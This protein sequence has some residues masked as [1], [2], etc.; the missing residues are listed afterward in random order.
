MNEDA[1]MQMALAMSLET[2]NQSKGQPISTSTNK[3]NSQISISST[4]SSFITFPDFFE[5][6]PQKAGIYNENKQKIDF[7][8]YVRS[9]IFDT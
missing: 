5:K 9:Y 1:E 3:K 8:I 6:L 7:R 4:S 2:Q